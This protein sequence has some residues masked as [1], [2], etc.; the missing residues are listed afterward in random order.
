V[1]RF[2]NRVL[3]RIPPHKE[4]VSFRMLQETAYL[5]TS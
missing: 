4:E 5:G 1:R 3:R 2:E